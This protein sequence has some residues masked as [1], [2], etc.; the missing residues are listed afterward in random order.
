MNNSF[1]QEIHYRL[2]NLLADEPQLRQRDMAE[3][4]GISVGKV[5]YCLAQLAKKGFI[6]VKRFK[7]AK[8]KIPYTYILTPVGIEEKGRIT[9][10]FLKRKLKEYEEIKRQIAV[11]TEEVEQNGLG[12]AAELELG[13]LDARVI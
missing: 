8:T 5:N 1:E 9:V 3:R 10:R 2:L 7:S 4:M 6:K 11:L 13:N 12:K